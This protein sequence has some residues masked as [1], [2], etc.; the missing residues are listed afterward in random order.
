METQKNAY[1]KK[2]EIEKETETKY[3]RASTGGNRYNEEVRIEEA[4]VIDR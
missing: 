4:K 1:H 3:Q 2:R